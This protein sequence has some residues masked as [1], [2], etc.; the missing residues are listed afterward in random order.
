MVI[1]QIFCVFINENPTVTNNIIY[2]YEG[3]SYGNVCIID[4]N[5]KNLVSNFQEICIC[6]HYLMTV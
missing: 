2:N 3:Q 5:E 6:P 4:E 1:S